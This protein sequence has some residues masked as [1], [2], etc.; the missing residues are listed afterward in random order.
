MRYREVVHEAPGFWEDDDHPVD[1][2]AW[3]DAMTFCTELSA[4]P[5]ERQAG[6]VYRLPTEAEWE[7]ACRAGSKLPFSFEGGAPVLGEYAWFFGNAGNSTHAVGQKKPNAWGLYDMHGNVWEWC[8]D[9]YDE[10]HYST[11][12]S[13]EG[14]NDPAKDAEDPKGPLRNEPFRV[15][16]GGSWYDNPDVCRS[17]NRFKGPSVRFASIGFRVV[18]EVK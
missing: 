17:A 4:I 18:V 11:R 10:R 15:V 12:R 3:D 6:R 2:I 8:G 14:A 5:E 1:R 9:W 16:R 13:A 7:Y